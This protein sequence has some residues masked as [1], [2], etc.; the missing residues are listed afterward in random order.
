MMFWSFSLGDNSFSIDR[1]C[2]MAIREWVPNFLWPYWM[3]FPFFTTAIT[4]NAVAIADNAAAIT[5]TL[6]KW[7]G[8]NLR[9]SQSLKN[10]C[11]W[12]T[13]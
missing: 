13:I 12:M 5:K 1:M 7:S 4:I 11:S 8:A 3:V 6:Q 2:S 10:L 9:H